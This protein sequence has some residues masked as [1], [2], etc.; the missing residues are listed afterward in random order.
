MSVRSMRFRVSLAS[1]TLP[2]MTMPARFISSAMTVAV[3]SGGSL[4]VESSEG[5]IGDTVRKL[6]QISQL[7]T[8]L[9]REHGR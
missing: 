8:F 7:E 3:K 6:A 2:S 1:L 9:P 5:Q 4:T